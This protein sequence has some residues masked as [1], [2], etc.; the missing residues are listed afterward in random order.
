MLLKLLS[1]VLK[2]QHRHKY[3]HFQKQ[4]V[5]NQINYFNKNN[6]LNLTKI[7]DESWALKNK[8]I[9][10]KHKKLKK[11][12]Y[13][14]KKNGAY[15]IKISGAGGGGFLFCFY[16]PF[17]FYNIK[18]IIEKQLRMYILKFSIQKKGS[19]NLFI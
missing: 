3:L 11:I 10:K 5:F 14:I 19:E 8:Q 7:I 18:K 2:Q 1:D 4:N 12:I 16:N 6:F 13:Q 15:A 17:K 9:N